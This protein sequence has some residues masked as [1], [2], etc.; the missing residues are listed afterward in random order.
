[1]ATPSRTTERSGRGAKLPSHQRAATLSLVV[2]LVFVVGW[3]GWRVATMQLHP[4]PVVVLLI[5]LSGWTGGLL[6]A[7]GLLASSDPRHT[8]HDDETYRYASAVADRVGRT[9]AADLQ[10][11]LRSATD[12]L[13][14]RTV[15]GSADRAMVGVMVDGPR[16]IALVAALTLCLL[17]GVAPSPV[18]PWWA[19]TAITTA[20]VALAASHVLASDRRIRLGDRTRWSYASLGEVIATNDHADVA[21]RRWVGT[22]GTIVVL[23][24]AIGL[25]GMSD[26][27]THGLPAMSDDERVVAMAWAG[28]LVLGGLY[29]L[30][31]IPTPRLGNAHVVARRLAERTAR[32]SALGAA[33]GIG[34]I[35]LLAGILPGGVDAGAEDPGGVEAP[36]QADVGGG[37]D[38]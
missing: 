35:G 24:L 2:A 9:R 38:D 4:V 20:S 33:V 7:T 17:I 23:N 16:R 29:S 14:S 1:M 15:G 12:R 27:W 5:E 26:R 21:P 32:Q 34:L 18:P 28:L 8:E 31:T 22:V 10:R 36:A 37:V 13:R 6:V 11:D 30:R 19:I 3:F 25:R